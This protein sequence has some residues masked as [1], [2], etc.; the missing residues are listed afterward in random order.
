MIIAFVGIDGTGKS[1]LLNYFA[2][3]L[4]CN[5]K[6]VHTIKALKPE[7][8]FMENYNILRRAFLQ[9][10][11]NKQHQLNVY[12]SYIMS[13]DLLQNSEAIKK[14]DSD[15]KVILLDRWAIC[16]QLYAKV[17]MAENEFANIA[18]GLC[19]EPDIT[20]VIDSDLDLVEQRLKNRGG[21]NEH[22]NIYCLCRLKR[23]YKKYADTKETA[24]LISNNN[25]IKQAC[26]TIIQEY[27]SRTK[28]Q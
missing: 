13:F 20:F 11:P 16:Q 22:E 19:L 17:W 23:L 9:Q 8:I 24:V 15:D 26:D 2:K 14:L 18:Y 1:T 4:E 3:Y 28:S 7:S 12:G 21:A 10:Y 25:D 27:E 6:V 5:G